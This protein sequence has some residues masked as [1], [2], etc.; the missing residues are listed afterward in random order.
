MLNNQLSCQDDE[1]QED[2]AEKPGP[3]NPPSSQSNKNTVIDNVIIDEEL[4][5]EDGLED[6]DL[7][8]SDSDD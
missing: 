8:D 4:F 3:A 7:D 5:V 2:I 6:L 1:D